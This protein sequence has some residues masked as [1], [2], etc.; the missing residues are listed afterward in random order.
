MMWQAYVITFW[1][2]LE[3]K[4]AQIWSVRVEL[5]QVT[6]VGNGISCFKQC[7]V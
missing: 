1:E 4:L 7:I 3:G 6:E 2:T 5:L